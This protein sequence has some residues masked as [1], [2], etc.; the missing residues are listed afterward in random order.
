MSGL[1]PIPPRLKLAL[2][3]VVAAAAATVGPGWVGDILAHQR[4]L[5]AD[6]VAERVMRHDKLALCDAYQAWR[7]ASHRDSAGVE[8][9]CR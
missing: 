3:V 9:L 5:L 7:A 4:D 1:T 8:E 2:V 6:A